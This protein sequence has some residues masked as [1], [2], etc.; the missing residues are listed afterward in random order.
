MQLQR[1]SH[2]ILNWLD[3]E[4]KAERTFCCRGKGDALPLVKRQGAQPGN[5]VG[6]HGARLPQ[7]HCCSSTHMFDPGASKLLF[8]H[9]HTHNHEP[10]AHNGS[11]GGKASEKQQT[12]VF[13]HNHH[14][15][16]LC[17]TLLYCLPIKKRTK[18]K[19]KLS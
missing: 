11:Q 3:V 18:K 15:K 1:V 10:R 2:F 19:H 4:T 5:V 8:L 12:V 7:S 17:S 13:L 14:T 16:R 9:T 6:H